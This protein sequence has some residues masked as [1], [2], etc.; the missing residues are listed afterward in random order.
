MPGIKKLHVIVSG[1]VQGVFYRVF[2][3]QKA[4]SLGLKGWAKNLADG[5]VEIMAQGSEEKLNEFLKFLK[6]GPTTAKVDSIKTEWLNADKKF[7]AFE[8]RHL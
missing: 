8:I 7:S 6:N 4:D 1:K 5:S 3:K 2:T